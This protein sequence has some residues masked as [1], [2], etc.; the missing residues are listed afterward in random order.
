MSNI[1]SKPGQPVQPPIGGV[2]PLQLLATVAGA[3]LTRQGD[4]TGPTGSKGDPLERLLA[5][6]EGR[7]AAEQK[8]QAT[9]AE[10]IRIQRKNNLAA[11]SKQEHNI[12]LQ[13]EACTHRQPAPYNGTNIAGWNLASGTLSLVC[14]ECGKLFQTKEE[15]E[16]LNRRGLM[17]PSENIAPRPT[18]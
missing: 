2:D 4:P 9:L 17:P 16:F 13:Q 15:H 8:R 3:S 12:K 5:I 14:Q 18:A 10:Q 7:E 11:L 1:Q 6:I